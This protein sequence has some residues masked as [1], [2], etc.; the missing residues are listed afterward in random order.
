MT[1][2][3]TRVKAAVIR[4]VFGLPRPANNR[5]TGLG[6]PNAVRITAALKRVSVGV[7]TLLICGR[8]N[9]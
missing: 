8:R 1:P 4:T 3:R 5:R 7:M 2:T 6:N 9:A